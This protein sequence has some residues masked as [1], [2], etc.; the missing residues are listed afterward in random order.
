MES[1]VLD[2]EVSLLETGIRET[3]VNYKGSFYL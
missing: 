2:L 1:G 3:L